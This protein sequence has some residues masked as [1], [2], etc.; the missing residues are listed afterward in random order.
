MAPVANYCGEPMPRT[1]SRSQVIVF[2][3]PPGS[4]KGTQAARLSSQLQI[5][6][7]STGEL[8]RRECDSGSDLGDALRSVLVSGQLVNDGLINQVVANRFR[9][10]DCEPGCILDGYPRTVLQARFL[11]G[12][13][14]SMNKPRPVVLEFEISA[15]EIISR[16]NRRRQCT[17]CGH[18]FSIESESNGR[19]L[20]CDRDGSPL[21]Q[22]ADDNPET[23]R[24]RLRQYKRNSGQ[25]TAYYRGQQYYRIDAAR[26]PEEI[27]DTVLN[28]LRVNWSTPLLSRAASV[29]AQIGLHA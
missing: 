13:L 29:P 9:N 14:T 12:L 17:E 26:A 22:R 5:P 2:L 25:L 23:V 15:D 28:I 19:A 24:E 4:G 21:V 27:S 18:I 3:G 11:D 10:C 6:A 16:L 7:I 20:V 8:L 1:H